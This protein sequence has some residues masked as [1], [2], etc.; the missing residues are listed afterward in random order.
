MPINN[1]F[2]LAAVFWRRRVLWLLLVVLGTGAGIGAGQALSQYRLSI[3]PLESVPTTMDVVTKAVDLNTSLVTLFSRS[4]ASKTFARNFFSELDRLAGMPNRYQDAA[5][6]AV[7]KWEEIFG[8]GN[9][10]AAVEEFAAYLSGEMVLSIKAMPR[11]THDTFRYVVYSPY[12]N[13][14]TVYFESRETGLARAVGVAS[15]AAMAPAV[16]EFNEMNLNGWRTLLTDR[17]NIYKQVF[18]AVQTGRPAT[19][20]TSESIRQKVWRDFYE[21]EQFLAGKEGP[22]AKTAAP[23][24]AVVVTDGNF[25]KLSLGGDALRIAPLAQRLATLKE[26]KALTDAEYDTQLKHLAETNDALSGLYAESGAA[27]ASVPTMQMQDFKEKFLLSGVRYSDTL[28][29][30]DRS[31]GKTDQRTFSVRK[32][33]VGSFFLSLV[34]ATALVLVLEF[35]RA[36][37]ARVRE[38]SHA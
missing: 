24:P 12:D 4:A 18:Q 10:T 7:A 37:S 9:R 36:F 2:E 29:A 28:L 20:G 21:I 22:G 17:A 13:Q 16:Q 14:I 35:G 23:P 1:I 25:A 8:E 19:T 11:L 34:F 32:W 15:G 30:T 5:K 33:V 31:L 27:E 26:K 6:K 38:L 3:I